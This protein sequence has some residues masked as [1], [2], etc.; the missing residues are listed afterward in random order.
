VQ[1]LQASCNETLKSAATNFKF[2]PTAERVK[3]DITASNVR[4]VQNVI[5]RSRFGKY[6]QFFSPFAINPHK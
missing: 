4:L 1:F 3:V 5:I 6:N 2:K